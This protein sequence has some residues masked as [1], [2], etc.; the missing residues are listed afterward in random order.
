MGIDFTTSSPWL[1]QYEVYIHEATLKDT[2][3]ENI[4][5]KHYNIRTPR[6]H[7]E[8]QLTFTL[9]DFYGNTKTITKD[10]YVNHCNDLE[11]DENE[12]IVLSVY[13]NPATECINIAGENIASIEICNLL[14]G[15][16]YEKQ[17]CSNN[18]VIS[19]ENMPAGSYFVRV[20][21]ADGKEVTKKI[22]VM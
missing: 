2:I 15:V 19:T 4:I 22:I 12:N 10:L 5:A 16:V 18:N 21:M 8:Q 20:R 3:R 11:V 14:G 9:T 7:G 6:D 13:P 17:N 1:Y